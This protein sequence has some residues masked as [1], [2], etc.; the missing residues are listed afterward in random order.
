MKTTMKTTMK[1]SP[2]KQGFMEVS[3]PAKK[4]IDT[5]T[6]AY[7]AGKAKKDAASANASKA[8]SK[9]GI[10]EKAIASLSLIHI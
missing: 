7:K 1:K 10:K 9:N 6:A 5:V 4:A 8:G 3:N 2:L